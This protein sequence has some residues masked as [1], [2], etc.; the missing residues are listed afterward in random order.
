VILLGNNQGG[1]FL[2]PV[3]NNI[4]FFFSQNVIWRGFINPQLFVGLIVLISVVVFSG[5]V[6]LVFS[7]FKNKLLAICL[8]AFTL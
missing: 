8:P 4:W 3:G 6:C 1:G 5:I 2:V 7:W